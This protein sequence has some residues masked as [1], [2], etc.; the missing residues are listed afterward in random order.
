MSCRTWTRA[1]APQQSHACAR[2]VIRDAPVPARRCRG[3]TLDA[4]TPVSRR[5]LRN[6]VQN[7][8]K[9]LEARVSR[10]RRCSLRSRSVAVPAMQQLWKSRGLVTMGILD[11][12]AFGVCRKPQKSG[13]DRRN[14]PVLNSL[15]CRAS[16][17]AESSCS[18]RRTYDHVCG[19]ARGNSGATT[20][21]PRSARRSAGP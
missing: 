17:A 19:K 8:V 3:R 4:G 14:R 16:P 11:G 1:G 18:A 15:V 9:L 2:S 10:P 6:V 21:A 5:R 12:C 7:R 13:P 20:V